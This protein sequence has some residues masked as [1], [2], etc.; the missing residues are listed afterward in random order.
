MS[1]ISFLSG[2][3]LH[4]LCWFLW[5]FRMTHLVIIRSCVLQ[6]VYSLWTS[7]RTHI[8]INYKDKKWKENIHKLNT[9]ND[10][11]R[12]TQRREFPQCNICVV[13][14]QLV[15]CCQKGEYIYLY[16]RQW[17]ELFVNLSTLCVGVCLHICCYIHE[18]WF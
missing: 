9:L 12:F 6:I 7:E 16:S 17:F 3:T 15:L 18:K 1:A 13:N 2:L 10:N 5:H 14:V 8:L 11:E 4:L